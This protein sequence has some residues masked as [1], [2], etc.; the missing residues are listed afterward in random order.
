MVA[1]PHMSDRTLNSACD[2]HQSLQNVLHVR[3][4]ARSNSMRIFT[5]TLGTE[6]NSFA[7]LPTGLADFQGRGY[8]PTITPTH[9]LHAFAQVCRVLRERAPQEG[10]QLIEGKLAFAVPAGITTR[11]AYETLRD[12]LLADLQNAMPVDM[13]LLQVHG[14][15]IADGYLD[16]EGDLLQR[17]RGLVGPEVLVG[18]ELDPHCHLSAAKVEACDLVV[19]FKEYPH[20]DIYERAQDLVRL[21]SET[22]AGRIKPVMRVRDLGFLSMIPTSRGVGRDLVDRMTALEGKGGILSVSLAHGFPWGDSPDLGTR[23]LVIA[24]GDAAKAETVLHSFGNDVIALREKLAPPYPTVKVAIDKAIASNHLSVVLADTA[25]NPGGGAAGDSTFILAEL[26]ARGIENA[27][28]G[29]FWD[30]VAVECCFLA[31][32]GAQLDLRIGGKINR[33]SGQPLDVSPRVLA[34]KRAAMQDGLSGT[35]APLGDVAVVDVSGIKIVLNTARTQAF[36]TDM[37]TQFGI[38]LAETKLIVVKSSN[39]FFAKYGPI[40][41]D[42]IYVDS[43]AAVPADFITLPY[44]HARR[45]IWPFVR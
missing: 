2:R 18:A 22:R 13:V 20:T 25:D 45:T 33:F 12:Q 41:S 5:A 10:W 39:H 15:M 40:A 4:F 36:G 32:I 3:T 43:P 37:F 8:D 31:G 42:V 24:D 27:V 11:H 16:A 7:P 34:L 21:A 23:L 28:V 17:V 44:K 14:A 29:P 19:L 9:E 6:T 26:L 38:N 1:N 30:P 35:R